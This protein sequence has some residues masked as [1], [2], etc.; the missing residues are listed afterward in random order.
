M[1]LSIFRK[2]NK[3]AKALNDDVIISVRNLSKVYIIGKQK[4]RALNDVDIDI[5]KGEFCAITGPS[6]SGKST[7][8]N[9]LAGLEPPSKG[10]IIIDGE[11][12]SKLNEKNLVRFRRRKVGFI[13]QSF[14]LIPTMNCLENIALP[15]TFQG[16]AKY[17][18]LK[19]AKELLKLV[20]LSSHAK[21]KPSEMSGGQ[22]QRIGVARAL[23]A[24]PAIIF[25]DEPTGNLDSATSR[26]ILTLIKN[27]AREQKQ[28]IVMVTHDLDLAQYADK[29]F[30][31]VDGKITRVLGGKDPSLAPP[32]RRQKLD[33]RI[34]NLGLSEL[35]GARAE[36]QVP[37]NEE[38]IETS[39]KKRNIEF[40]E[41]LHELENKN[42]DTS[43]NKS[44]TK[45]S[46]KTSSNTENITKKSSSKK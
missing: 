36:D 42:E 40:S 38:E 44:S 21:H 27:I 32:L 14:N 24:K 2:K 9:M 35:K 12:I 20:G 3:P 43:D 10:T 30:I 15:L 4:L 39:R 46:A 26:E 5:K 41:E 33:E 34:D 13:F 1:F 19:Q 31:I 23:V 45:S 25:A 28:T 22:Q 29:I 37:M 17:R 11:E 6:G 18:R 8:L 7:L 16:Q